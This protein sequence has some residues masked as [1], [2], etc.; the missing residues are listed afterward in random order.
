MPDYFL[1]E[2]IHLAHVVISNGDMPR[3]EVPR[4]AIIQMP[5]KVMCSL[6]TF[7]LEFYTIT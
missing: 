5:T 3:I 4:S 7:F 1:V 6:I 2:T